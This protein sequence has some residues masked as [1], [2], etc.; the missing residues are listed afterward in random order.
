ML[1]SFIW[2]KIGTYQVLQELTWQW[3]QW[4]GIPHSPKLQ[5]TGATPS[6]CLV[7]YPGHLLGWMQS[8]YF[9]APAKW[10]VS[11]LGHCN[12]IFT[13]IM[14]HCPFDVIACWLVWFMAHYLLWVTNAKFCDIY[15]YIY[16]WFV[17]KWFVV[18]LFS[19]ESDRI[20]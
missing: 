10:A 13:Y 9:T 4:R 14:V 3:C 7:S 17:S 16:I 15:I 8:V 18:T 20:C 6:D 12:L 5:I 19:N 11:H 1:N 2:P